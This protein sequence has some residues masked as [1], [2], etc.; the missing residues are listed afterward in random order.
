MLTQLELDRFVT[1]FFKDESGCWLWIGTKDS[2]GYGQFKRQG[3]R[4]Y[5]LAHRVAYEHFVNSDFPRQM[6]VLHKCDNPACVN[7]DHLKLGTQADNLRDCLVKGRRPVNHFSY[8]R[9]L[10]TRDRREEPR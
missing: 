8:Q 10:D 1:K 7:P 5:S 9:T 2:K 6:C 4:T 3:K